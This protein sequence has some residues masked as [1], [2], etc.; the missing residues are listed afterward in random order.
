M[1]QYYTRIIIR[2]DGTSYDVDVHE[3]F[4]TVDRWNAVLASYALYM[5]RSDH[6][7]KLVVGILK[8][9]LWLFYSI[10]LIATWSLSKQKCCVL[11]TGGVS[12]ESQKRTSVLHTKQAFFSNKKY[13]SYKCWTCAKLC[14]DFTFLMEKRICVIWRHG[15]STHSGGSAQTVLHSWR[16]SFY[17]VTKRILC[18]N[19]TNINST[20][21]YTCLTTP[22]DIL[23]IYSPSITLNLRNI[24]LNKANKLLSYKSYW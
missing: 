8:Y 9:L 4:A 12:A 15:L 11:L 1:K 22:H 19:F 13:D 23:T 17:F 24:Q 21:L 2:S 3:P 16:I 6:S 14:E 10:H 5:I 20:T 18:L 7:I